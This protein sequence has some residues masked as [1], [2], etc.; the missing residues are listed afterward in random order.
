MLLGSA[1]LLSGQGP[2]R[3]LTLTQAV[4]EAQDANLGLKNEGLKVGI[5]KRDKDLSFNRLY[6]TV[7]VGA[8]LVNLND[9]RPEQVLVAYDPVHTKNIYAAVDPLN[10]GLQFNTQFVF[11]WSVLAAIDQTAIDYSNSKLSYDLASERLVR[12]VK[13]AFFQLLVLQE[14]IRVTSNQLANA[15]QRY[16][17][18]QS[19]LRAGQASEL[20][21]LQAKVAWENRKPGLDDL[22]V[23]YSQLLFGF[24]NLLGEAPDANVTLQGSLDIAAPAADPDPTVVDRFLPRRLDV[25]A[26]QGQVAALDGYLH[27][28]DTLLY[29]TFIVQLS[30][31][32]ALNGPFKSGADWSTSSWYQRN[33]ALSFL[34]NWKLDSLLPDSTFANQRADLA[35]QGAQARVAL[36]QTR[37]TA[38]TEVMTLFQKIK[39]S[40]NALQSLAENVDSA[41]RAYQLTETAYHSGARSLLE[42]QDAE[43]QYQVAQLNL[44]NE[45]QLLNSNLL[46]LETALHTPREEIYGKQ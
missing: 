37:L 24:E 42:V 8:G 12:D 11:S 38:R 17:E 30:A 6:P 25:Q 16:R 34:L 44:L 9:T 46:D 31:D 18:A 32:P 39:K 36:D 21:V 35:D 26:A 23:G 40:T 22:K 5:K 4:H 41:L 19:N 14:S 27:L 20:T 33:G 29:P 10:L 7:S 3:T 15:E 43:L 13:K 1:T 45:K 28:Q 2:A